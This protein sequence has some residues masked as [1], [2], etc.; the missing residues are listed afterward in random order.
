MTNKRTKT[1]AGNSLEMAGPAIGLHNNE[2]SYDVGKN[3]FESLIGGFGRDVFMNRYWEKNPLHLARQSPDMYNSLGISL[4]SVD[5]MLRSNIIEF[6]KNLD[7]TSYTNGQRETHNP[8]MYFDENILKNF[9]F[10][11]S[12]HYI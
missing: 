3:L 5:E 12:I 11:F 6:T 10:R 1:S 4:A 2:N 9:H 8:G 7:I